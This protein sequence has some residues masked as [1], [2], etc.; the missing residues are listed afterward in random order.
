VAHLNSDEYRILVEQAPIMIWRSDTS[1]G[2]DYFNQKW[3]AFTGATLEHEL[4]D[5]WAEGVHPEDLDR[6]LNIYAKAFAAHESF[7]M[8]YRLRDANGDFRWILDEGGPFVDGQGEFAGFIG[9]CIDI[10]ERIEAER[11]LAELH[12]AEVRRLNGLLPICAQCKKIRD[13]KGYWT[14]V[15]EYVRDHSDAEFSHGLCPEC[16]NAVIEELGE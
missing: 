14:E 8:E 15:E 1:A 13:D 4:G 2:C 12:D 3:L 7:A 10:T 16:L 11:A 6:C 9:S 5:G